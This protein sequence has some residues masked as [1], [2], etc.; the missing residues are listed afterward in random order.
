MTVQTELMT[1]EAGVILE[2]KHIPIIPGVKVVVYDDREAVLRIDDVD[3]IEFRW[4]GEAR[5]MFA[6]LDTAESIE[7]L[8]L[9]QRLRI[10]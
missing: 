10:K 6:E 5:S 4:T 2:L 1:I 7:L 9:L 3:V 8:E